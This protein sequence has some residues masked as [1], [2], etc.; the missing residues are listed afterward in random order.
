MARL[1]I[2]GCSQRKRA[3]T[4]LLPAIER[5]DGPSYR[6]LRG[7]LRQP[8]ALPPDT[9]VLSAAFGLIPA[10][11]PIPDYDHV[12]TP[13][14]ADELADATRAQLNRLLA[15]RAFDDVLVFAGRTYRQAL[16]PLVRFP[17]VYVVAPDGRIGQKLAEL[18]DWLYG[19]LRAMPT[20]RHAPRLSSAA[21]MDSTAP[22]LRGV[23]V[24][25]DADAVLTIARRALTDAVG[26]PD[27]WHAWYVE[28]DGRRVAPKWLVSQLTGL[29]TSAFITT[30]ARRLLEQ[31]GVPVQRR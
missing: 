30:E 4:A 22:K 27:A 9:W 20:A 11:Q 16:G 28:V 10:A 31:L 2:L 3:D 29:P 12:M 23:A 14:R 18:H 21:P 8:G 6:V 1:L 24:P 7:Y 25:L 19:D 13:A 17:G 15:T 5:Y 26:D